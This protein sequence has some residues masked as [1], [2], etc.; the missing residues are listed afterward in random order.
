MQN[1]RIIKL[2]KNFSIPII[3]ST[4][5]ISINSTYAITCSSWETICVTQA[6]VNW[7]YIEECCF[8]NSSSTPTQQ[9]ERD[10]ELD[11]WI[12]SYDKV[13]NATSSYNCHSQAHNKRFKR[14]NFPNNIFI[15][16]RENWLTYNKVDA[17]KWDRWLFFQEDNN[18]KYKYILIY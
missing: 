6:K 2:L 15:T 9:Q 1:K 8:T 4:A 13:R 7:K 12:N 10:F 11:Y 5:F 14:I 3:L 17:K 18:W 16:F